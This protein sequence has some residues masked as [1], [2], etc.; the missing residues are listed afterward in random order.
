MK[1]PNPLRRLFG[2]EK[3]MTSLDLFREVYGGRASKAGV[4]VNVE[5]AMG[6]TTALACGRV[7]ADGIAQVPFRLYRETEAGKEKAID[8][9]LYRLLYRRPNNWQSAFE[10]RETLAL[11]LVFTGNAFVFVNRVG[12]DRKIRELVL[13]EPERVKVKKDDFDRFTYEVSADKGDTQVFPAEAIWHLRGPSWN[14][15]QGMEVIK[16]ARD[17][18]GLSIQLEQN[19][20]EFG[21]SGAKVGGLLSVKDTLNKEQYEFLASWL[22]EY[23]IGGKRYNKPMILDRGAEFMSTSMSGV[24]QQLIETRKHQVEEVCRAF[25]VMP[26]MVGFTDKTATYAS[27]EQMFLAHVVHTLSPWYERIEQSADNNLLS[28]DEIRAG[29]YTKF[30]PNALM[31]GAAKDRA[32]YYSRGLGSGG[33]KGWLTQNDVREM[34]EMNRSDDPDADRLPQPSN[35]TNPADQGTGGQNA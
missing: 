12:R 22:E 26:I 33:V 15:W 24:D 19:Q 6:V 16:L 30:S 4:K 14:G 3:K 35:V 21:K 2:A 17:A 28:E 34:E 9:P 27:S 32:E 5:T 13:I 8:H 18:L 7:I 11:H 20:A 23:E 25:R 10:F 1:L 31:R 29:Y